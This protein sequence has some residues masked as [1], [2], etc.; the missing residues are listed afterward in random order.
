MAKTQ[1]LLYAVVGAG[2]FAIDKARNMR[3][4]E[5]KSAG[6]IYTDFVKRG[7]SLSKKIRT[8]APSKQA[9]AQTKTARTQVKA[10]A[11]SVSKAIR[12]NA[13]GSTKK[14]ADQ[15]KVARSQVKA[16]T[17]SVTKAVK[18][19]SKAVRSAAEKVVKAS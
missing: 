15:T 4:I 6:I 10:A 8:S 11:T 9:V 5:T 19:N 3:K 7:Q 1:E 14:A 18:A 17:T 12:A 13:S 2:D 16:A